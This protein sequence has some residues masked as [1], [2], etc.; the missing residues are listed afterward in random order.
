MYFK[1][2]FDFRK[3]TKSEVFQNIHESSP[4]NKF[5]KSLHLDLSQNLSKSNKQQN[6][7]RAFLTTEILQLK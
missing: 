4:K 5:T 2:D 7:S 1:V 6:Q 3:Q